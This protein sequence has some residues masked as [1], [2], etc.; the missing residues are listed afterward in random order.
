[1]AKRRSKKKSNWWADIKKD[2]TQF[3]TWNAK[4]RT[5]NNKLK[6]ERVKARK[7]IASEKAVK[8]ARKREA[9]AQRLA[10]A[11]KRRQAN[12][13]TPVTTYQPIPNQSGRSRPVPA[14]PPA[15]T[16]DGL[17]RPLDAKGARFFALRDSGYT[18]PIDQDGYA[19]DSSGRRTPPA[20]SGAGQTSGSRTAPAGAR[21]CGA[22]TED[23]SPC[24]I[25]IGPDGNCAVRR[26]RPKNVP[27]RKT[28][29]GREPVHA[30]S[31]SQ[32]S[33]MSLD[34]F[35]SSP[36]YRKAVA[37]GADPDALQ[38]NFLQFRDGK[39]RTS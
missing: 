27:T 8:A 23:G 16:H 12:R 24:Q 15:R 17:G 3:L 38:L 29:A 19:V 28:T 26:H 32:G 25:L 21:P 11:E 22:K 18:G 2:Y 5:T 6:A 13:T 1:M 31:A 34:A 14:K 4:R 10:D 37:G 39:R 36:G 20:I 33:F 9:Q 7:T 30:R 35:T